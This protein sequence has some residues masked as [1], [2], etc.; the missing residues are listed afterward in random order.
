MAEAVVVASL[1][2]MCID[3]PLTTYRDVRVAKD[4]HAVMFTST[5]MPVGSLVFLLDTPLGSTSKTFFML[6]LAHSHFLYNDPTHFFLVNFQLKVTSIYFLSCRRHV[7]TSVPRCR[8]HRFATAIMH[9][10]CTA[11]FIHALG[12]HISKIHAL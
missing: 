3:S 12:L 8:C 9:E 5:C 10:S 6:S 4:A 2:I 11:S 7:A 1:L